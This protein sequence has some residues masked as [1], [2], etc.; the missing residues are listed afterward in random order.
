MPLPNIN[1]PN[2]VRNAA[3]NAN[4]SQ[5]DAREPNLPCFSATP[6]EMVS[7][8]SHEVTTNDET[9]SGSSGND[10]HTISSSSVNYENEEPSINVPI[11]AQADS[12]DPL[13]II[14][15]HDADIAVFADELV[16]EVDEIDFIQINDDVFMS[17]TDRMP[18]PYIGTSQLKLEDPLSGK[19]PFIEYVSTQKNFFFKYFN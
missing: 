16:K 2:L 10:D 11:E 12:V 18:L 8:T 14:N 3:G 6:F 5:T 19:I 4:V 13:A 15:V 7:S 1:Q 9:A 17:V